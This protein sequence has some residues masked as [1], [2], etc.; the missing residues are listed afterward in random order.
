MVS[1]GR[2]ASFEKDLM[3]KF[4]S[5]AEEASD[6]LLQQS[7]SEGSQRSLS[8]AQ[9]IARMMDNLTAQDYEVKMKYPVCGWEINLGA[10]P[11]E[12][13]EVPC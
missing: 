2:R 7:L 6:P 3:E 13:K 4:K 12:G 11:D 1:A 10:D 5:M 9:K 8:N